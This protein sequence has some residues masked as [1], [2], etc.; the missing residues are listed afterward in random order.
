MQGP[1]AIRERNSGTD[2]K[3]DQTALSGGIMQS[4]RDIALSSVQ[5]KSICL[6]SC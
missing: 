3:V 2:N 4:F 6:F 5:T 1:V